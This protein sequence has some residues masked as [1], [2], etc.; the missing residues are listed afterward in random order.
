MRSGRREGAVAVRRTL[1]SI[2]GVSYEL[3]VFDCDGVLVD[4]EMLVVEIEAA[5][6]TEAGFELSAADVI[7][8]FVG[9]SYPTMMARIEAGS[10]SDGT[11]DNGY[12]EAY[13]FHE[14]GTPEGTPSGRREFYYLAD[15]ANDLY[16]IATF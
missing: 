8:R 4:S 11:A 1:V 7:D 2:V 3:V 14:E 5:L 16:S 9:L 15:E 13:L 6:L 10:I 12:F